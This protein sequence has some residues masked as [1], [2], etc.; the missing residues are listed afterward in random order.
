MVESFIT[1]NMVAR[2]ET[3][4]GDYLETGQ[5]DYSNLW[6]EAFADLLL[7]LDSMD[8][9]TR[10]L[11]ERL[12]LQT[13]VTKT[14]AFNGTISDED[15]AHRMR[16]VI[17]VSVATDDAVFTLQGTDDGGSTWT[18]IEMVADDGTSATTH[19]IS[20]AAIGDDANSYLVMKLYKQ[21]RL[22]LISIDTT[23]TYS[24]YMIEEVYT[25]LHRDKTRALIYRSLKMTEGDIWEDKWASYELMY[26]KRLAEGR[27]R[28]DYTDDNE[29]SEREGDKV[30]SNIRFGV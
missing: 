1:Q 12:S 23:T 28:V 22:Q 20:T 8:L 13:S 30:I 17:P 29:I 27:L 14:A 6:K 7:D 5:S 24:A 15:F 10:K 9:D 25:A 26:N 2:G 18:A 11:C 16:L 21:Y 4:I 19:T 3:A